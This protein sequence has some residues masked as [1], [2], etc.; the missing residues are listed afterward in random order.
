MD[1]TGFLDTVDKRKYDAILHELHKRVSNS[2]GET[3]KRL[4]NRY[5]Q[6]LLSRNNDVS[7]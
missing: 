2:S 4:L 6:A 7:I 5:H 3:L 1:H